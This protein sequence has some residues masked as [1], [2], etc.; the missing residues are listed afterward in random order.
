MIMIMVS[1]IKINMLMILFDRWVIIKVFQLLFINTINIIIIG[2]IFGILFII[3]IGTI[4]GIQITIMIFIISID[5]HC[6]ISG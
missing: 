4:F 5:L 6:L 2:L 3:I 1:I